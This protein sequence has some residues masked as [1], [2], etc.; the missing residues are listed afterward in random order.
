VAWGLST[1]SVWHPASAQAPP[2]TAVV[3]PSGREPTLALGGLLQA[4][5]EVGDRAD[6]R[7]SNDNDRF[8]LRRARLNASG[9]FLE[10]FDFRAELDLAGSLANT[11]G[12]RAQMTDG[13]IN[14]NRHPA[15]NLRIGQFKTPFGFEQL[16]S[17][18]RLFTLERTLVNDRLTVSR[19]LGVQVGGDLLD[20]RLTYAVGAFNGNGVNNNFNDD[21]RFMVVG[22]VAGVPWRGRLLGQSA[23]WA[24]GGDGYTSDDTNLAMAGEF[25]FD[26]TPSTPDRDNLFSGRRRAAGLD[27]QLL[28]GRLEIWAE[29]LRVRFEPDSAR[30]DDRFDSDGWYV[31][32]AYYVVPQRLQVVA[33]FDTFDPRGD[34]PDDSTDATTLGAAYYLK[35]HDLKLQLNWLRS[36]GPGGAASE[37]RILARIQVIF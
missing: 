8:Y 9:R 34:R 32:A 1:L 14:W 25:G 26:S 18:P 30:P 11:S 27:T 37:D 22:R 21:D 13:Y 24:L 3:K 6:T 5:V 19:Q 28:A 7:F 17:D 29:Y 10:E 2:G 4:Q 23:S 33:K 31:Q 16:Y 36:E 35:G 20:R 12:L 15:A